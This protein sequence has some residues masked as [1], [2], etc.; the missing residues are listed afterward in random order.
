MGSKNNNAQNKADKAKTQHQK[1]VDAIQAGE[2]KEVRPTAAGIESR[3]KSDYKKGAGSKYTGKLADAMANKAFDSSPLGKMKKAG[4][5]FDALGRSGL[6]GEYNVTPGGMQDTV[7]GTFGYKE[8]SDLAK[9]VDE[10]KVAGYGGFDP[11]KP[12]SFQGFSNLNEQAAANQLFGFSPTQNMGIINSLRYGATNPQAIRGYQ[13]LGNLVKGIGTLSPIQNV[14]RGMLGIDPVKMTEINPFNIGPGFAQYPDQFTRSFTNPE[15]EAMTNPAIYDRLFNDVA[16]VQTG[17]F[18]PPAA[19]IVGQQQFAPRFDDGINNSNV[20]ADME[21]YGT[22]FTGGAISL[23]PAFTSPLQNTASDILGGQN[24]ANIGVNSLAEQMGQQTTTDFDGDGQITTDDQAIAAQ[25]FVSGAF[26]G[27]ANIL[28]GG[29]DALQA[30]NQNFQKQ[31]QALEASKTSL[32]SG[33]LPASEMGAFS[34]MQTQPSTF[35]LFNP[36]TYP[37][38]FN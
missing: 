11:L 22:D 1:T 36:G 32:G 33:S 28:A 10:G 18:S 9:M 20:L 29:L 13:Q 14:F 2:A 6:P 34:N 4:V 37:N 21:R 5:S 23:D 8:Y 19:Q 38:F 27:S 16:P 24:L 12:T 31:Q 25:N 7:Q 30:A 17:M 26:P 3:F 15:L 35:N